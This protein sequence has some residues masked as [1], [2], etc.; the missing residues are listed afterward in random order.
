MRLL[1]GW[2]LSDLAHYLPERRAPEALRRRLGG[3][4]QKSSQRPA[5]EA[6]GADDQHRGHEGEDREDGEAREEEDAEGQN[7]AVDEGTEERAPEGAEAADDHDHEGLHDDVGVHAG[8]DGAHRRDEGAAQSAQERREHEDAGVERVHVHAERAQ[9]LTVEGRRANETACS[10]PLKREPEAEGDGGTEEDDEQ[11]VV[12][13]GGA[14]QAHRARETGRAAQRF[15]LC[16]PDELGRIAQ[17]EYEGVGEE[18]LVELL[19]S[20]Q[21]LEEETLHETAEQGDGERRSEGG[22]PEDERQPGRDEKEEHGGGEAAQGLGEDERQ[23]WHEEV[24]RGVGH[25][26]PRAD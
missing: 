24:R 1:T 7:L 9:G 3:A 4:N 20:I 5:E 10:R 6:P 19:L 17:D 2:S 8:H 23:V 25:P 12:G 16:P 26:S 21:A 18:E 11:V 15:L 22:D 14:Q 13:N